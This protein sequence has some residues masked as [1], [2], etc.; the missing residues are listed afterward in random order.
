MKLFHSHSFSFSSIFLISVSFVLSLVLLPARACAQSTPE[1]IDFVVHC[2]KGGKNLSGATVTVLKNNFVQI[3]QKTTGVLGRAEFDLPF[4]YDY[5]ITFSAPGCIDMFE[6]V[7]GST[8]PR[9]LID[10][11]PK[12][13][14]EIPF[15]EPG[16]ISIRKESFKNAFNKIIFDGRNSMMDDLPYMQKFTRE[17]MVPKEEQ[18]KIFK[19][20]AQELNNDKQKEIEAKEKARKEKEAKEK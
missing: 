10:I 9:N 13:K 5:K 8:I 12:Y 15:F 16:D 2:T 6:E 3:A 4:G 14:G 19:A 11:F 1:M 7:K 18:E 20:Q 17:V